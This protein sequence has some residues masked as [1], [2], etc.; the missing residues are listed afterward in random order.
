MTP[1]RVSPLVCSISS[2]FP[3]SNICSLFTATP[4]VRYLAYNR[5]EWFDAPQNKYIVHQNC[6]KFTITI[7]MLTNT[8]RQ[9]LFN[10][11]RFDLCVQP[12]ARI[13]HLLSDVV[14]FFRLLLR[15]VLSASLSHAMHFGWLAGNMQKAH[16]F[17]THTCI[18]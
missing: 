6:I 15:S 8:Q 4:V 2:D 18:R 1:I 11:N 14:F 5:F 10:S 16:H 9:N 12:P 3:V 13:F 7:F 17:H